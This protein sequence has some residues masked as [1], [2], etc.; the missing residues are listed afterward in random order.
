MKIISQ[1]FHVKTPC[2][3]WDVHTWDVKKVCLQTLRNNII[4]Q[5]LAYFLRT[6]RTLRANNLRVL[7][8]KKATTTNYK[9]Q[10]NCLYYVHII[11]EINI[12]ICHSQ[13]F[14]I[15]YFPFWYFLRHPDIKKQNLVCEWA[16]KTKKWLNKTYKT[17]CYKTMSNFSQLLFSHWLLHK[18]FF[19]FLTKAFANFEKLIRFHWQAFIVYK[20]GENLKMLIEVF[21]QKL[22]A[23]NVILAFLDH[24][25][26]KIFFAG[27]PWW[28]T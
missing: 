3:F 8:N 28:P 24:L 23:S 14:V 5:K 12:V 15:P 7:G 1:R 6:L 2:T 9:R 11:F 20:N 22:I 27:Q 10:K 4:R 26:H 17:T 18:C 25:K 19:S 13:L 16:C 21:C